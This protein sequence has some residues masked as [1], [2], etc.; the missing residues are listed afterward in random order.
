MEIS[1]YRYCSFFATAAHGGQGNLLRRRASA[2]LITMS[3]AA[4]F[5]NG[6]AALGKISYGKHY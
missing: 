2:A 5:W 3:Q 4:A 6:D 1:Q